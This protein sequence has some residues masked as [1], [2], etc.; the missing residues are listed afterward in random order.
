MHFQSHAEIYHCIV[1]M[2]GWFFHLGLHYSTY[3]M[4]FIMYF[5]HHVTPLT[6][7]IR[8]H[9]LQLILPHMLDHMFMAFPV[10]L[11]TPNIPWTYIIL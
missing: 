7:H 8:R 3:E 6:S 9:L 10:P 4:D 11:Q 1:L 5:G 2:D